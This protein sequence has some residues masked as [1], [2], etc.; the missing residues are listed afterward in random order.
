M[1]R[2]GHVIMKQ[3]ISEDI[4]RISNCFPVHSCF[5][6][7]LELYVLPLTCCSSAFVCTQTAIDYLNEHLED[8][9]Q[10][11]FFLYESV[12]EGRISDTFRRVIDFYLGNSSHIVTPAN[13][14]S[15]IDVSVKQ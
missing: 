15:I 6:T 13:V 5:S 8:V 4:S 10:V 9:A 11:V 7:F 1:Q 14:H 12:P 3:D 2:D